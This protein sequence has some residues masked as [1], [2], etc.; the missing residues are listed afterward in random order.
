MQIRSL[1]LVTAAASVAV[2]ALALSLGNG[3]QAQTAT[4]LKCNGCV[5]KK[6]VGDGAIT[7]NKLSRGAKPAAVTDKMGDSTGLISGEEKIVLTKKVTVKSKGQLIVTAHI[8]YSLNTGQGLYC[9]VTLNDPVFSFA[10][11]TRYHF[12]DGGF[13]NI[14]GSIQRLFKNVPAGKHKA[15]LICNADAG[16]SINVSLPDMIVLFVPDLL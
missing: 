5:G 9:Q 6:D 3:A 16:D 13:V 12:N 2:V 1:R 8:G 4:N 10:Q 11:P 7:K 14:T 15:R